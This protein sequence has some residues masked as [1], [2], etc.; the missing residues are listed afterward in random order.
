MKGS[1]VHVPPLFSTPNLTHSAKVD[2][3]AVMARFLAKPR[4]A[5]SGFFLGGAGGD[6]VPPQIFGGNAS[7]PGGGTHFDLGKKDVGGWLG[8]TRTDPHLG[9][10]VRNPHQK[11]KGEAGRG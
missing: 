9:H 11:K 10:N 3:S 8:V 4:Y 1:R 7:P 2:F 6:G 5:T